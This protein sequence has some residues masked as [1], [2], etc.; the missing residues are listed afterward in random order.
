MS[1]VAEKTLISAEEFLRMPNNQG[2]ELIDGEIVP[3]HGD[4]GESRVS[5]L[6]SWVGGELFAQIHSFCKGKE[7][8]W[9]FPADSGF[10]CFPDRPKNVRKPDLSFVKSGNMTWD[11]IT[12]GW[13][14]VVPNLVVEVVSPNDRATQLEK[15][16]ERFLQAGVPLL[17]IIYPDVRIVRIIR[18]D[19]STAIL[20]EGDE[21]S[22][23]EIIPGFVSPVASIFPPKSTVPA[24]NPAPKD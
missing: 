3:C 24:I 15:K 6:S 8:G 10:Q 20:R 11:Q 22:G 9:V 19:G 4:D 16:I 5:S 7:I 14:K 12:D 2:F 17:W 1:A 21:L 18:G 13:M 23:E